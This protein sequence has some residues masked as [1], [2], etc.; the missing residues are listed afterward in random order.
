MIAGAVDRDDTINQV[1]QVL[2]DIDAA[3][4]PQLKVFNKIDLLDDIRPHIAYDAEGKPSSVWISALSGDGCDL[5]QQALNQLFADRK[6][7]RKCFLPASQAGFKGKLFGLARILSENVN[8]L[9]DCELI[10]EI[11]KKHLG[12]LKDIRTEE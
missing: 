5:L 3:K 4:V 11:D 8:E 7:K 10:I 12:L 2:E 6:V 9:G 1:N